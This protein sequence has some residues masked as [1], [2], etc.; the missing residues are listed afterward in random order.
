MQF[1]DVI[2]QRYY[3]ALTVFLAPVNGFLLLN[4]LIKRLKAP[5]FALDP[6]V[7]VDEGVRVLLSHQ[8][9]LVF[10]GRVMV[11][12]DQANMRKRTH[13]LRAL[14][15]AFLV[16]LQEV[17]ELRVVLPLLLFDRHNV[18]QRLAEVLKMKV[19]VLLVC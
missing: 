13:L 1:V 7:D 16:P 15:S 12:G 10:E 8:L 5:N 3:L 11:A 4:S 14:P 19:Q 18:F 2:R 9:E 17:A 6:V